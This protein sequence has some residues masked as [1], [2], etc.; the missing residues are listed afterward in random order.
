MLA[1]YKGRSPVLSVGEG[2]LFLR[3]VHFGWAHAELLGQELHARV[4]VVCPDACKL[5]HGLCVGVAEV[6]GGLQEWLQE[7]P[8]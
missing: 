7:R 6:V 5:H 3:L 8:P 2:I 1:M 4:A